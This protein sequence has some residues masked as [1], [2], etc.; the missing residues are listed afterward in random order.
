MLTF[1][2]RLNTAFNNRRY[3]P[4]LVKFILERLAVV[5]MQYYN[6]ETIKFV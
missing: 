4:K 5:W 1:S 2:G 3:L 6:K